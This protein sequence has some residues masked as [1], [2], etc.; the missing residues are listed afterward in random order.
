MVMQ[1]PR[2]NFLVLQKKKKIQ[3]RESRTLKQTQISS[4]CWSLCDCTSPVSMKLALQMALC[5]RQSYVVSTHSH[6]LCLNRLWNAD[7][8][9]CFCS[10]NC[11]MLLDFPDRGRQQ[12]LVIP[13]LWRTQSNISYWAPSDLFLIVFHSNC[14]YDKLPPPWEHNTNLLL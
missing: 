4:E 12:S 1:S 10:A 13:K 11:V 2:F 5:L 9:S 8:F 6:M 7:Q 14:C 3:A